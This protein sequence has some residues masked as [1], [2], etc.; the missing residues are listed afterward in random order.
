MH[1][2]RRGSCPSNDSRGTVGLDRGRVGLSVISALAS[3]GQC[4]AMGFVMSSTERGSI[5]D[6]RAATEEDR[7]HRAPRRQLCEVGE[8]LRIALDIARLVERT[9]MDVRVEVAVRA[10]NGQNGHP[11]S[12]PKSPVAAR[13]PVFVRAMPWLSVLDRALPTNFANARARC[14]RPLAGR[15]RG[16]MLLLRRGRFTECDIQ[17]HR[18]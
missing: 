12:M 9:A 3:T 11:A 7:L 18:T 17:N 14:E 6:Q 13:S 10:F 15:E 8:L 5:S 2:E 4:L 16:R 1:A